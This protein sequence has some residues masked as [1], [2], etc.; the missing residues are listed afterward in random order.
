M[1]KAARKLTHWTLRRVT[2][3]QWAVR[4]RRKGLLSLGICLNHRIS[5]YSPFM[6]VAG[7][8]YVALG[9]GQALCQHC[10]ELGSLRLYDAREA[11]AVSTDFVLVMWPD[12]P[13]LN[14]SFQRKILWLQNAGWADTIPHF[15][16]Q[17]G[18]VFCASRKLCERFPGLVYLPTAC[19]DTALWRPCPPDPR[20]ETEVCFLGNYS[21]EGRPAAHVARYLVPA[22]KFRFAIWGS[23]WEA[24]QPPILRSFHR[25]RLSVRFGPVVHCSSQIVLSHHSLLHQQDEMVSG[26]VFDALACEAFVISDSMPALE[27]FRAYLVFTDGGEDLEEKIRYYLAHPEERHARVRGSRAWILAHHTWEQRARIVAQTLG[28]TWREQQA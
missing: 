21:K 4:P 9:L 10:P 7:D 23:G 1:Q 17:F 19:S 15:Q 12:Y 22:T 5:R 3:R 24:A 2:R 13:R 11:Q 16:A 20:F 8:E 18:L 6:R 25:G 26:R 27:E 28:L 14:G